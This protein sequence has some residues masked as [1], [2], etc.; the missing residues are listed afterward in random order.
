MADPRGERGWGPVLP[1]PSFWIFFFFFLQKQV[2]EQKVICSIKQ[3]RN[4]SQNAGNGHFRDSHFQNFLGEYAP[5]LP[6][7]LAP[8][9]LIVPPPPL[10]VLDLLEISHTQQFFNLDISKRVPS[11]PPIILSMIGHYP[12]T[13]P[14]I[15]G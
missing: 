11:A 13:I 7:K 5:R 6:R 4:L 2:Y 9:A 1:P 12:H 3:V 10:K 8:S 15:P 14:W